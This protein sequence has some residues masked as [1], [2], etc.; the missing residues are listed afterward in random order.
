MSLYVVT[1][2]NLSSG[3]KMTTTMRSPASES[4]HA[5]Y[6]R[7]VKKLRGRGFSFHNDLPG[8]PNIGR[9]TSPGRRSGTDLHERVRI[10]TFRTAMRSNPAAACSASPKRDRYRDAKV[11]HKGEWVQNNGCWDASGVP[12][13]AGKSESG[14]RRVISKKAVR[15]KA[16]RTPKFVKG[17]RA[18]KRR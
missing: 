15:Q 18:R 5:L 2:R 13:Y 12:S 10:D 1:I 11:M 8:H 3:S 6:V 17:A 14:K 4:E 7:A 16:S 9:I